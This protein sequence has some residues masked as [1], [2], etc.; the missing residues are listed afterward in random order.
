M[1]TAALP[2]S[3]E[4][5]DCGRTQPGNI[6]DGQQRRGHAVFET[7]AAEREMADV[8]GATDKIHITRLHSYR[9]ALRSGRRRGSQ[10][11]RGTTAYGPTRLT[12]PHKRS[13]RCLRAAPVVLSARAGPSGGGR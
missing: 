9:D 13:D 5:D 4:G 8:L 6:S 2:G 3:E 11:A 1:R 10:G 7:T 12:N